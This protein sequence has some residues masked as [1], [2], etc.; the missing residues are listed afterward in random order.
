MLKINGEWVSNLMILIEHIINFI[1]CLFGKYCQDNNNNQMDNE[2]GIPRLWRNRA[3]NLIK[4]ACRE[5]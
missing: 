4:R 2:I 5:G 1:S 3:S